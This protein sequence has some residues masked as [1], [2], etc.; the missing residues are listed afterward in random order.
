LNKER[1]PIP[2]PVRRI[3]LIEAGYQCSMPRCGVAVALEIH[4]MDENPANNDVGNLLVLCANHH[5]QVTNRQIDRLACIQIKKELAERKPLKI[6]HKKLASLIAE[7]LVDGVWPDPVRADSS[8]KDLAEVL[9][10]Q[11]GAKA[12]LIARC[13]ERLIIWVQAAIRNF[14]HGKALAL[15]VACAASSIV[16]V[17]Q[18]EVGFSDTQDFLRTTGGPGVGAFRVRFDVGQVSKAANDKAIPPEFW[19]SCVVLTVVGENTPFMKTLEVPIDEFERR[20]R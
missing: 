1:I 19:K 3:L 12:E 15:A 10:Q 8:L 4:H 20:V 18:L 16:G 13:G 14:D 11:T 7:S 6:D 2:V 5:A 9:D 17:K